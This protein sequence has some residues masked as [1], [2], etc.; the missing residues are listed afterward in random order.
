LKNAWKKYLFG[1]NTSKIYSFI[2]LIKNALDINVLCLVLEILP[3]RTEHEPETLE[4]ICQKWHIFF[5]EMADNRHN[6]TVY[7][8]CPDI[9]FGSLKILKPHSDCFDSF[10]EIFSLFWLCEKDL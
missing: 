3:L 1:T 2:N 6:K 10:I 9:F 7:Y 5:R 8:P 4:D